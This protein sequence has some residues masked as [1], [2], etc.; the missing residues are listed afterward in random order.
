[1]RILIATGSLAIRAGPETYA[2]DLV[3]ALTRAGH[4]VAV[5]SP[6]L[7]EMADDFRVA[8]AAVL[9]RLDTVS[10]TPEILHGQHCLDMMTALCRFPATPAV[11]VSH[12]WMH[13]GDT[14]PRHPRILR[15]VAVDGPTRDHAVQRC[16]IPPAQVSLVPN[17][18]DLERY[19]PRAPLPPRPQR[20]LV[21]S[22]YARED[23]YLPLVREACRRTGITVDVAG[24]GVGR[25]VSQ[26]ERVLPAY[27]VVFAKG[28]AALEAAAVGTAVVVCDA[29]G[30]GPM[31]TTQ[32]MQVLRTLEGDYWRWYSPLRVDRLEQEIGRYDAR[33]A[34]EVTR[35]VREVAGADRAGAELVRLYEDAV[36]EHRERPPDP[37]A[38]TN[39]VAQH[40][41]WLSRITKEDLVERDPLAGLAVR[42][43]NRLARVPLAARL[44]VRLSA[45]ARSCLG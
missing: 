12:G 18:V 3:G 44:L 29:F 32:N 2:R 7:G 38:E 39:A 25:P 4:A 1:M 23:T 10:W 36:A 8:G 22:N 9:D 11:F 15:Y 40:L 6:I 30:L 31:V 16:G 43:R 41:A 45:M 27:D 26:P 24:Y 13:W 14:P 17:F 37:V 35:W 33:D 19:G 28:R 21:L 34:A 20:A 42:L 5:Y